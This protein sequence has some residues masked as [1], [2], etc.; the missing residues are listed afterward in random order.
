MREHHDFPFSMVKKH[1]FFKSGYESDQ[2]GLSK[3]VSIFDIIVKFIHLQH[4]I[5]VVAQT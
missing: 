1:G 3:K 2:C 4:S 5:G